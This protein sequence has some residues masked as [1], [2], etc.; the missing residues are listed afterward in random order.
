MGGAQPGMRR[1]R[2]PPA[3]SE[4]ASC[5]VSA[6]TCPAAARA[7]RRWRFQ[8]LKVKTA[9]QAGEGELP[10]T[11]G[12]VGADEAAGGAELQDHD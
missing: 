7:S 6:R 8:K 2:A 5:P 3:F 4:D 10:D 9:P 11:A 1:N 12:L